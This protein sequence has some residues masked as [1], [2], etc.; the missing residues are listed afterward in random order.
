MMQKVLTRAE[1]ERLTD[2]QMKI[3]SVNN[4][5]KQVDPEKIPD[6]AGIQDCLEDAQRSLEEA[7]HSGKG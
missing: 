2:S 5:L 3:Q 4:S 6:F 1:K 7:L